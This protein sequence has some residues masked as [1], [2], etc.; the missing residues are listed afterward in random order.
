M[1]GR[2]MGASEVVNRDEDRVSLGAMQ[3]KFE[4]QGSL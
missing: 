2:G 4:A 1:F 3:A